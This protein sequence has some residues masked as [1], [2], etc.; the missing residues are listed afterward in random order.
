MPSE[1][2]RIASEILSYL[3][4]NP[5]S[6]DTIEGIRQWWLVEKRVPIDSE[7]IEKGL[8]LLKKR[9]SLLESRDSHGKIIYKIAR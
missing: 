5:D 8:E 7:K 9:G 6:G 2:S 4:A 3:A 1:I